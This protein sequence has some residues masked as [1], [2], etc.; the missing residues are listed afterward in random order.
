MAG[1]DKSYPI[2]GM[3]LPNGL[4]RVE[5]PEPVEGLVWIYIH[6]YRNDTL[7]AGQ[8]QDVARRLNRRKEMPQ[9]GGTFRASYPAVS[10]Q[11]CGSYIGCGR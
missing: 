2:F 1:Q 6:W 4:K 5:C 11:V 7:Y 3:E 10:F 9:S 8:S